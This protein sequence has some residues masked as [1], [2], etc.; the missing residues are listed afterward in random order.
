VSSV[1]SSRKGN[2]RLSRLTRSMGELTS[3]GHSN[4]STQHVYLIPRPTILP[5]LDSLIGRNE[6]GTN[7]GSC[8]HMRVCLVISHFVWLIICENL[9]FHRH[10]P[11]LEDQTVKFP[12]SVAHI[13][14][15][16][17]DTNNPT[18]ASDSS[19]QP[20]SV[21]YDFTSGWLNVVK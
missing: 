7:S 16:T 21:D 4:P 18:S 3:S 13:S 19:C 10:K 6:D 9:D 12:T 11:R 14:T 5:K 1:T 2:R 8:Q 15:K 20:L 17:I